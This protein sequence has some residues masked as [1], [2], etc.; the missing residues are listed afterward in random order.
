M[1]HLLRGFFVT[2]NF[3]INVFKVACLSPSIFK[4]KIEI[5]DTHVGDGA[6]GT[7]LYTEESNG[8]YNVVV[9]VNFPCRLF[10]RMCVVDIYSCN[11]PQNGRF[12]AR[13][14]SKRYNVGSFF[15]ISLPIERW[16]RETKL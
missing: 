5:S 10:A 2:E 16:T 13:N 4:R 14:Y 1:P 8:E 3:A 15:F 9:Y 11:I 7:I 6:H 12:T